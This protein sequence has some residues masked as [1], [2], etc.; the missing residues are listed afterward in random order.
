MEMLSKVLPIILLFALG[1]VIRKGS[2]ISKEGIEAIKGVVVNLALPAILFKTFLTM[3]FELGQVAIPILII[4]LLSIILIV[5]RAL[6]K[7]N[8]IAHKLTPYISSGFCFGLLGIPLFTIVFGEENLAIFSLIGLGHEVFVWCIL[9][10]ILQFDFNNE[11]FR[12]KE[13]IKVFKS[14]ILIS[15]FAGLTLNII[16]LKPL[17]FENPLLKGVYG[18]IEYLGSVATPLILIAIGFGIEVKKGNIM[19]TLK[20]LA[21]RMTLIMVIGYIFKVI[22]INPIIGVT[23]IFNYAYFTFLILP[24]MFS[25]PMLVGKYGTREDEELANNVVVVSTI[26][27]LIIFIVMVFIWDI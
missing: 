12:F 15:I 20:L 23:Q 26:L 24:P 5:G 13:L 9:Y 25:L 18:A 21:T 2:L 16:G 19:Q 22:V 6:N 4:L 7:I 10:P 3:E 8:P 1:Y 11:K 14:A 17:F 27:S